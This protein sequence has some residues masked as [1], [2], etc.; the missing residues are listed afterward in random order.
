MK[1][2]E[3]KKMIEE[4]RE[5]IKEKGYKKDLIS[6]LDS[7]IADGTNLEEIL[8]LAYLTKSRAQIDEYPVWKQ[9]SF[10]SKIKVFIKKIIRKSMKFYIVPIVEKQNLFN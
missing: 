10:S 2:V 9:S 8:S 5:E 4:I 3:I 6:F 1:Q 7:C